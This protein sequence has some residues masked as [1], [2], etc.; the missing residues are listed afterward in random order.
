MGGAENLPLALPASTAT[1]GSP[2]PRQGG[3]PDE[4][5]AFYLDRLDQLA[6]RFEPFFET[7]AQFRL[8]FSEEDLFGFDAEAVR[9]VVRERDPSEVE[10]DVPF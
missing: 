1:Q 4:S 5:T 8:V 10:D 6:A 2:T 9:L 3:A 7:P